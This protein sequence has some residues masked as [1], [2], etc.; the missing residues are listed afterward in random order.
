[1]LSLKRGQSD[2]FEPLVQEALVAR[3]AWFLRIEATN[4]IEPLDDE[5]LFD[6]IRHGVTQ[7]RALGLTWTS[8]L[9]AFVGCLLVVGP[10]FHEHPAVQAIMTETALTPDERFESLATRLSEESWNEAARLS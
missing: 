3:I 8:S 2:V 1:M 4:E 7:G 6:F 9:S 10:K 5:A